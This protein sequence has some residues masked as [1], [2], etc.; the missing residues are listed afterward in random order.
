VA[1]ESRI[2]QCLI[3]ETLIFALALKRLHA[4]HHRAHG[5]SRLELRLG[6]IERASR[7]AGSRL[8]IIVV[9]HFDLPGEPSE[10]MGTAEHI[11][12]EEQ[13]QKRDDHTDDPSGQHG[14]ENA[15]FIIH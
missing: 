12:H 10:V 2:T 8:R 11:G 14:H 9:G 3:P 4:G 15:V 1:G 5:Q 7:R 13:Q 6:R